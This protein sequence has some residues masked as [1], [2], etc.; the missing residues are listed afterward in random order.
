M[1]SNNEQCSIT[2]N[3]SICNI[4]ETKR[5]VSHISFDVV[6]KIMI[7]IE[8]RNEDF[9]KKNYVVICRTEFIY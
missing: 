7:L 6:K 5:A 3:F 9:A 4:M 8:L 2:L 1:Q